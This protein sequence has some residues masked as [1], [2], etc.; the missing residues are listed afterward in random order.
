MFQIRWMPEAE[1]EYYATLQYWIE[2]NKSTDYSLKIIQEVER[3][4]DL[5]ISNP[6]LGRMTNSEL[7]VLKITMLDKFYIY[8]NIMENTINILAFKSA[9][10]D[11][12]KHALGI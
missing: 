2:H 8:Y 7:S 5:L 9:S 3:F 10:E 12:H 11:H 4:E 6:Q 1:Q